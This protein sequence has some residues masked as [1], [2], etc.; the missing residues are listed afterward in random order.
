MEIACLPHPW[1][2][3]IGRDLM[4]HESTTVNQTQKLSVNCITCQAARY[5]FVLFYMLSCDGCPY[6]C[7]T[8][9]CNTIWNN[10]FLQHKLGTRLLIIH[11]HAI[12][13]TKVFNKTFN[14]K[15]KV[16]ILK[17]LFCFTFIVGYKLKNTSFPLLPHSASF[18]ALPAHGHQVSILP[19]VCKVRRLFQDRVHKVSQ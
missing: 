8:V 16:Q 12:V 2:G 17:S 1:E 5:C 10:F 19:V 3:P 15:N 13:A 11:R 7:T 18:P 6:K 14:H 9:N 4:R